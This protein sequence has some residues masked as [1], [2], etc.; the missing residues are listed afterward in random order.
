MIFSQKFISEIKKN[1][2]LKVFDFWAKNRF[3][4]PKKKFF[5]TKFFLTQNLT[6]YIFLTLY[7]AKTCKVKNMGPKYLRSYGPKTADWLI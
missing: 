3:L 7:D 4:G 2:N 6:K 5:W 1:Q